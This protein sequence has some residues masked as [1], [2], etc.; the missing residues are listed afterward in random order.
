MAQAYSKSLKTCAVCNF[1]GGSR[2]VDTF[3]QNVTVDSP[4]TKGRCLLQGGPW[5]GQDKAA[6]SGCDKW[7][8]W[9]GLK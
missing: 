5:K 7:Q 9:A 1:W 2:K 3:G 4:S 6:G 8:A